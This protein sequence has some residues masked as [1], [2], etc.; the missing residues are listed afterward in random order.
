[1]QTMLRECRKE[2]RPNTRCEYTRQSFALFSLRTWY[3]TAGC[4]VKISGCYDRNT[5]ALSVVWHCVVDVCIK[6]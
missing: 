5:I 4:A 2:G 3:L 1:M 6:M